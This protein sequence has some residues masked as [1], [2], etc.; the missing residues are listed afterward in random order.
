LNGTTSTCQQQWAELL[1]TIL[2]PSDWGNTFK[3]ARRMGIASHSQSVSQ[4][5]L[6]IT[7]GTMYCSSCLGSLALFTNQFIIINCHV[8]MVCFGLFITESMVSPLANCL[9]W[10]GQRDFLVPFYG[11]VIVDR[12]TGYQSIH[13]RFVFLFRRPCCWT[14]E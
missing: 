2:D 4:S 14:L 9:A 13:E 10:L 5:Q 12:E 7:Q 11:L 1:R 3:S 6:V 8:C